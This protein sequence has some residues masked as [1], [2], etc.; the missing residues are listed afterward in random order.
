MPRIVV[1]IA[2]NSGVSL[3]ST[4]IARPMT[5]QSLL[6]TL[7]SC[8]DLEEFWERVVGWVER[9]PPD[10]VKLALPTL[11]RELSQVPDR[12]RRCPYRWLRC[13]GE[14]GHPVGFSLVR[15]VSA[16]RRTRRVRGQA[17]GDRDL[18]RLGNCPELSSVRRFKLFFCAITDQGARALARSAYVRGVGSLNLVNNQVTAL[19]AEAIVT[20][21]NLR[22]LRELSLSRNN[23][24]D[25]GARS[26]ARLPQL[27]RLETFRLEGCN[28]SS[29]GRQVLRSCKY[30][31]SCDLH[32]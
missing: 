2:S 12:I 32:V 11:Q 6:S 7:A 15:S 3:T 24:S 16:R 13:L 8:S 4:T 14:G 21:P 9:T 28:L 29:Q 19:G 1:A 27:E 25:A 17:I 10:D 23:I 30:L 5:F 26:L 22:A 31:R 20:S 18:A